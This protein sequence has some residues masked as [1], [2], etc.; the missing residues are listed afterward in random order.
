MKKPLH[1]FIGLFCI[2]HCFS[3]DIAKLVEIMT[4][5]SNQYK[6]NGSVPVFY[7]GNV[8]LDKGYGLRNASDKT[9]NDQESFLD[10]FYHPAIHVDHDLKIAGRK[11]TEC[12][13]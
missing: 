1:F 4:A 7:K 13:R 9:P 10:R 3:Q 6:F 8:L 11:K 5:Y 2:D 12:C